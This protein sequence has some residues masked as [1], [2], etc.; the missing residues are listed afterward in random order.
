MPYMNRTTRGR[1]AECIKI[2]TPLQKIREQFNVTEGHVM[3]VLQELGMFGTPTVTI[4]GKDQPYFEGDFPP[5]MPKY[6]VK[7]LSGHEEQIFVNGPV[8]LFN[9]R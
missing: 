8:H 9:I 4:G 5:E 1:V 6:S 3:E 2:G 7:D